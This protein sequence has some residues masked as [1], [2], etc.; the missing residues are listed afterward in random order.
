MKSRAWSFRIRTKATFSGPLRFAEPVTQEGVM[1]RLV[2]N[3]G[4]SDVAVQ[5]MEFKP[6]Q[7]KKDRVTGS[8]EECRDCF[9]GVSK[10]DAEVIQLFYKSLP[11]YVLEGLCRELGETDCLEPLSKSICWDCFLEALEVVLRRAYRDWDW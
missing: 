5:N 1:H 11:P 8:S 3:L 9:C 7:H 6:Y 10:E 4:Y 2:H